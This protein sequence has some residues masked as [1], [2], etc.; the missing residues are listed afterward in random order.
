MIT[1]RYESKQILI[2]K[3][4][5]PLLPL[6]YALEHGRMECRLGKCE[7]RKHSI[8][9]GRSI[10]LLDVPATCL[11]LPDLNGFEVCKQ[12]RQE[13]SKHLY[14]WRLAHDDEIDRVVGFG[15]GAMMILY[16]TL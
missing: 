9:T 2:S 12:L 15:I 1:D 13:I 6:R 8:S 14:Y 7:E 16:Q 10:L 11:R 3:T 5:P 4:K